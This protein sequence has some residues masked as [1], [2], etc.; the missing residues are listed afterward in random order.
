[1]TLPFQWMKETFPRTQLTTHNLQ[2]KRKM[3]TRTFSN[4][5]RG[6][7]EYYNIKIC[8]GICSMIKLWL[9][10]VITSK[11]VIGS[12]WMEEWKRCNFVWNCVDARIKW[13]Q[14]LCICHWSMFNALDFSISRFPWLLLFP[15]CISVNWQAV[16]SVKLTWTLNT[17][18]FYW[19][20]H[21][22]YLRNS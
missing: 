4:W 20:L 12:R 8:N 17:L 19:K 14:C 7:S 13:I 18:T 5:K 22:I 10:R 16:N 1:M 21:I 11:W 6:K 15:I 2:I 9:Y 3:L